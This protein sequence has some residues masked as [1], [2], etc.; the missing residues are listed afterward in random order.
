MTGCLT[1]GEGEVF[2]ASKGYRSLD[3]DTLVP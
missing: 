3:S 1:V 2:M